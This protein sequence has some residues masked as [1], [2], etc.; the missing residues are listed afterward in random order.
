MVRGIDIGNFQ[1]ELVSSNGR[2]GFIVS[3]TLP[4]AECSPEAGR[5]CYETAFESNKDLDHPLESQSSTLLIVFVF[6][7]AGTLVQWR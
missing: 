2:S 6:I 5:V 4:P 7:A 3:K 1:A